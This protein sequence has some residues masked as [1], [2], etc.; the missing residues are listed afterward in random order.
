MGRAG[1]AGLFASIATISACAI[2]DTPRA[3]AAELTPIQRVS[4][5]GYQLQAREG[6][7]LDLGALASCPFD[8]LVIDL[9]DGDRPLTAADTARL[10]S[11]PDKTRRLLLAYLSIGEAEDYRGYFEPSWKTKPPS[12]LAKENKEWKGNVKVRFWDP[13]WQRLMFA[14]VDQIVAAGFDGAYLDIIDAFEYFGPGGEMPERPTAAK[15]MQ[16]FVVAIARHARKDRA[17]F[18]IVPQNGAGILDALS[19]AEAKAYLDTIDAIGAEDTF[20]EGDRRKNGKEAI[21]S[22]E[23]FK[24]AGRPVLAVDYVSEPAKAKKFTE[25]A[26]KHGFI[27][28]VGT[29]ELDRLVPQP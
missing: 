2:K 25:L 7:R 20:F 6:A 18:L 26:K 8:L 9:G 21:A 24:S 16:S 28:Y 19:P 11:K 23:R 4:S 3:G 14:Y 29:R 12:F 27:P 22:L 17:D 5:W 10:K 13:A 15:D 1:T